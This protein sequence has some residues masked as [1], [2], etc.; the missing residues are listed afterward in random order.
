MYDELSARNT[1]N[2]AIP[3]QYGVTC[4]VYGSANEYSELEYTQVSNTHLI[5]SATA[6]SALASD[7]VT[8]NSTPNTI[9]MMVI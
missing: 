3:F 7:S 8:G 4:G 6:G 1:Y 5:M 9:S 2:V